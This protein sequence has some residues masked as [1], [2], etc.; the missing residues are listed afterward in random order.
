MFS[1]SLLLKKSQNKGIAGISIIFMKL[2]LFATV[3]Q[4]LNA[5]VPFPKF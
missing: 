1:P 4:T 3:S 5:F 2:S